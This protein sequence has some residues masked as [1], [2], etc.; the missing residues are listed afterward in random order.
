M[1]GRST[2]WVSN[3]TATLPDIPQCPC[4]EAESSREGSGWITAGS[5]CGRGVVLFERTLVHRAGVDTRQT[6]G[7]CA[8]IAEE[9]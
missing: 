6:L 9:G 3:T 1:G 5:R 7:S 8:G 2:I 4:T